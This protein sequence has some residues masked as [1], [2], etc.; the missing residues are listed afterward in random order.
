ML[1]RY[2]EGDIPSVAELEHTLAHGVADGVGVPG[3]VR[4]GR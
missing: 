2:L 1:E 3:R 4:L